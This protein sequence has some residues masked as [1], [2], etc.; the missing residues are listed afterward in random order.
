VSLLQT[1]VQLLWLRVGNNTNNLAEL[2]NTLK[3]FLDILSIVFCVLL[4]IFGVSLALALVPVLVATTL[5]SS[6]KCSAK[7]VVK[8]RRPR[9]VSK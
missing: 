1:E 6:L 7:T 3:L 8:V 5:N 4:G 9:G 2:G